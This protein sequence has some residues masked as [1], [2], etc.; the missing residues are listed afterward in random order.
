MLDNRYAIL[1]IRGERSVMDDKYDILTHSN[2]AFTAD[3]NTALYD[4][5][6]ITESVARIS[7]NFNATE[8]LLFMEA[9][10]INLDDYELITEEELQEIFDL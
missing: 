10:G 4:H 5:G 6:A 9:S 1:F 8:L 7:V 3:G 2:L